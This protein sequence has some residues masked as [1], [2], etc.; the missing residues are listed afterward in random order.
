MAAHS[1]KSYSIQAVA[2]LTG[3]PESKLRYY[4]SIGIIEPIERDA[5]SKHRVY[6]EDNLRVLDS[7]ACLSATGMSISDMREY[8]QN[9]NNGAEA[10]AEQ[11]R[12]LEGQQKRL[13]DEARYLKIRQQYVKLKIAYWKAVEE[14]DD[15]VVTD[16]GCCARQLA[17]D[18]KSFSKK[19]AN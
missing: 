10:A 1:T 18:L 4:E 8:I 3:L 2:K 5:S 13:A 15:A 17:Q 19:S 12:L 16:T 7:I 14:N 11:I 6:S 9:R